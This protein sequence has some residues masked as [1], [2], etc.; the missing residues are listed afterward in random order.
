MTSMNI[1]L[2]D[3]LRDYVEG[4][5]AD[6]GYGTVSEYVRDLIRGDQRRAAA[7][8]LESLLLDG[9]RSGDALPMAE[10]DWS[11]IRAAVADR[12]RDRRTRSAER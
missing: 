11:D 12:A 7:A 5:I 8:T 6:G 9:I 1:S 3:A 2:P 4:R 10:D